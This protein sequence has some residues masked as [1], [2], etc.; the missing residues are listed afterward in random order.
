MRGNHRMKK[1]NVTI[2]R[3]L[4]QRATDPERLLWNRVRARR[5]GG[6]KIRRQEPL[7]GYVVDFVCYE[8]RL[9]VELDGGH[10]ALDEGKARDRV[11]DGALHE[12]GF[13]VLRFW[14]HEVMKEPEAMLEA[15]YRACLERAPSPR[16]SPF[17]GEGVTEPN[18]GVS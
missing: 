5:L 3:T 11:R 10:H 9:V 18:A 17:E 2:S 14:N 7:C 8:A 1:P 13:R 12:A 15:V 6:F 4:R 16:P